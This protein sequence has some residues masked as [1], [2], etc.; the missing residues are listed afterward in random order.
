MTREV[1][2]FAPASV[3]NVAVGFDLLGHALSGVGD[4][5]TARRIPDPVVRITGIEPG[6]GVRFER[7]SL[8]LDPLQ[9]TA[10]AGLVELIADKNLPFGFELDILKGIP[11]GWGMGGSAASAG[12]GVA[13]ASALLDEPLTP[14][15]LLHY[16]LI[17]ESLASGS[18]HA[19][20]LAPC[21]FGGL[22]LVAGSSNPVALPTPSG[23]TCALA[24][25]DMRLD[26]RAARAV[27]GEGYPI[28][29]VVGQMA[30]LATFI[31]ACHRDD[32]DALATCL[33]DTLVEPRRAH[34]IPGFAD[35][36]RAALDAG[37]LGC[38]I[39]GAGPSVFAWCVGDD[40]AERA[41]DAMIRA[42]HDAGGLA[43]RGW[44]SPLDAPG[45][46]PL[47]PAP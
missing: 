14:S 32:R 19:D 1:Q 26:T 22:Q 33:R 20:N 16:G 39:S 27:L 42:F 25:P 43:A 47:E 17:G 18:R 29:Q 13:A 37:A 41:L 5:V 7:G 11:L 46:H 45:V 38:S 4:V 9:N 44:T 24:L 28:G 40:V 30:H 3:G 12:G 2:I 15:E 6:D 21:L 36:Q 34:L 31:D 23:V 10:T 35:V 8:P